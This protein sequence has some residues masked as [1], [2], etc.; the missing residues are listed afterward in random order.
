MESVIRYRHGVKSYEIVRKLLGYV[1]N[2]RPLSIVDLNPYNGI[3][4]WI[5]VPRSP[6]RPLCL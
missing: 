2:G 4:R 5:H 3:E 1:Y 6:P